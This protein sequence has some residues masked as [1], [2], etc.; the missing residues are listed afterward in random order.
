M[1]DQ[2]VIICQCGQ[3]NR[4]Q[5][6]EAK[7]GW[8][9]CGRCGKRLTIVAP[10]SANSDSSSASSAPPSVAG[11]RAPV[12]LIG[13]FAIIGVATL[14]HFLTSTSGSGPAT[15]APVAR[16]QTASVP[17]PPPSKSTQAA[18][19]TFP[20]YVPPASTPG[21]ASLPTPTAPA[22]RPYSAYTPPP[23]AAQT[24]PLAAVPI[25]N[26]IIRQRASGPVPL[27]VVADN[28][29]NYALKLVN[30]YT[31]AEVLL[32]YV[33]GGTDFQV[34][35]PPGEYYVRGASG[36]Q[37][38]GEKNLFGPGTSYFRMMQRNDVSAEG[39]RFTFA[40]GRAYTL[41]LKGVVDGN[42]NTPSISANEF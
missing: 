25:Y 19:P 15:V 16:D 5:P 13:F 32:F 6:Q 17:A 20:A 14:I 12:G 36:S 26:R 27:K 38:Y 42:V 24:P 41:T 33:A 29:R 34:S 1:A 9:S 28:G 21:P 23:P 18:P 39:S 35:V 40:R 31:N 10:P 2:H 3:W 30:T 8:F 22:P 4:L 7:Q 37:W 11:R